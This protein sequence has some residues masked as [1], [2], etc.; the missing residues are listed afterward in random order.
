MKRRWST[1]VTSLQIFNNNYLRIRFFR[2]LFYLIL[3]TDYTLK[4]FSFTVYRWYPD[5]T[6]FTFDSIHKE[7]IKSTYYIINIFLNYYFIFVSYDQW[8]RW[9]P[10]VTGTTVPIYLC[11]LLYDGTFKK[12]IL[13]YRLHYLSI[14]TFHSCFYCQFNY[15][16]SL[17]FM[18]CPLFDVSLINFEIM[19]SMAVY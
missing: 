4:I 17:V 3:N 2:L 5:R 13:I 15:L 12:N 16:M 10:T 18:F 7:N 6:I 9:K 1:C 19:F 11:V 14:L 8:F